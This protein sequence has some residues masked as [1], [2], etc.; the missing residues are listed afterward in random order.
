MYIVSYTMTC[1]ITIVA[2]CSITF[3]LYKYAKLQMTVATENARHL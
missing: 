2:T 1:A 3:K